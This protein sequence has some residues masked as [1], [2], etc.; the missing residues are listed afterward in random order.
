ML[1]FL[2]AIILKLL[3]W[4]IQIDKLYFHYN[5]AVVIMAPHTSM[6]DFW[7]GRLAFWKYKQKVYF[8]IKKELFFFPIGY[9]LK[10]MGG[11]P[12]LR[13]KS[14]QVVEQ[15]VKE[16]HKRKKMWLVITPEGTR[17]KVE[18]WKTGFY[19][20][21]LAA[22][23]PIF[24]SYIDYEKKYGGIAFLLYPSGDFEKDFEKIKCFYKTVKA[25]YPENFN[26][27]N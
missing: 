10:C 11:I 26:L 12:V 15:L 3:G 19:K 18:K 21:A 14:A 6:M 25:R 17:K 2:S 22:Q 7:I 9:F 8:L 24:V 20:I 1:S 13:G 5:S 23:L 16:F 4:K 27:S